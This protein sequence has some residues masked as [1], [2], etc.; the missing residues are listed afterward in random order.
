MCWSTREACGKG[1]CQNAK[2]SCGFVCEC[3][4]DGQSEQRDHGSEHNACPVASCHHCGWE[5]TFPIGGEFLSDE[6]VERLLIDV[7]FE[8]DESEGRDGIDRVALP[9]YDGKTLNTGGM[10]AYDLCH[11]AGHG[12]VCPKSRRRLPNF[13]LGDA[14]GHAYTNEEASDW[15]I[16]R[17]EVR[18]CAAELLILEVVGLE[19]ASRMDEIAHEYGMTIQKAI[20][21]VHV[22]RHGLIRTLGVTEEISLQVEKRYLEAVDRYKK[23]QE[24][25]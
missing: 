15:V 21:W 12:I 6:A 7:G 11:E 2:S 4:G 10:S 18:A 23:L 16:A 13:G 3:T 1:A 14:Y 5:G 22:E 17:E 19:D 9:T 25:V 8:L 20:I 24:V